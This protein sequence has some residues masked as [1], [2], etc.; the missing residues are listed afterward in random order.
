[1]LTKHARSGSRIEHTT[2]HC[3]WIW[4]VKES[5]PKLVSWYFACFH[6][7]NVCTL[8]LSHLFF[9]ASDRSVD[10]V[11]YTLTTHKKPSIMYYRVRNKWSQKAA[12][13][14]STCVWHVK[15]VKLTCVQRSTVAWGV[16][17]IWSQQMLSSNKCRIVCIHCR[18]IAK[19]YATRKIVTCLRIDL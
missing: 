10:Q 8:R 14:T 2:S 17:G 15:A 11:I 4:Y 12:T 16:S 6:V 9:A 7:L 5:V 18:K 3:H 13:S 19:E 1:M